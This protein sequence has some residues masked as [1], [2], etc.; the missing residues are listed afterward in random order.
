M[1]QDLEDLGR[2]PLSYLD[3]EKLSNRSYRK[4]RFNST[5][6]S[7]EKTENSLFDTELFDKDEN[8]NKA[9]DETENEEEVEDDM[10]SQLLETEEARMR[11]LIDA[12]FGFK[13]LEHSTES[14]LGW[15]VNMH[16][17]VVP[18]GAHLSAAIPYN[19]EPFPW[20]SGESREGLFYSEDGCVSPGHA[21]VDFYFLQEVSPI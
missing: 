18:E 2:A 8:P 21:S 20:N 16:A 9:T 4:T 7:N 11:D 1:D 14:K 15:L 5:S 17:S 3:A 19:H 6:V 10:N 13:R 12:R